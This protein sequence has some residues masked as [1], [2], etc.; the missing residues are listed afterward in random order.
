MLITLLPERLFRCRDSSKWYTLRQDI[1]PYPP[2]PSESSY[3]M[4]FNQSLC[5]AQIETLINFSSR[6]FIMSI[7]VDLENIILLACLTV[8]SGCQQPIVR[9]VSYKINPV[10]NHLITQNDQPIAPEFEEILPI[11]KSQTQVPILLPSKLL[12]T[13]T[14][15]KIY[16]DGEGNSIGYKITLGFAENCTAGACSIG[17][18]SAEKAG[19]PLADEFSRE[20]S[21]VQD[22]KGYF[23]PLTCAASCAPSIIG[24]EYKGVFYRITL[25]GVG[26]SPEIEGETLAKMAN[27]AIEAGAR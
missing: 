8:F 10:N 3:E 6:I 11:I 13:D 5:I 21:L 15:Q 19:L 14:D 27:S 16:I 17:Y 26:Q 22:I 12:I 23:R 9:A 1:S 4:A 20:L 24:W 2:H 7:L 18:F 25:K